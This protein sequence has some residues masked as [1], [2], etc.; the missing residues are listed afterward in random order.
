MERTA[1]A[2]LV[3]RWPDPY[4]SVILAAEVKATCIDAMIT[5]IAAPTIQKEIGEHSA[6]LI[7]SWLVRGLHAR[8]A[9]VWTIITGGRLGP[10]SPPLRRKRSCFVIRRALGYPPSPQPA[11]PAALL[12]GAPEIAARLQGARLGL[13]APSCIRSEPPA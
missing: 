1:T 11:L 12:H 13:S 6:R 2:Y 5:Q 10:P 3:A 8:D 4:R 9:Q 7:H